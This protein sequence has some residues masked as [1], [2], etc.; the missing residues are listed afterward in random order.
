LKFRK[1]SK[2]RKKVTISQQKEVVACLEVYVNGIFLQ[3]AEQQFPLL[4]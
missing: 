3:L 2:V 4:V 1:K